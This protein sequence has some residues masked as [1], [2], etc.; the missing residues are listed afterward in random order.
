MS[1]ASVFCCVY[2][3]QSANITVFFPLVVQSPKNMNVQSPKKMNVD[4]NTSGL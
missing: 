2:D 3:I 1:I 4:T